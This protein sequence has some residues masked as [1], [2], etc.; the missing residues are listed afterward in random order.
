MSTS[1]NTSAAPSSR[2]KSIA[3]PDNSPLPG[4][5]ISARPMAGDAIY[6]RILGAIMEHRLTPGTK[7]VEE[8]L[9]SIFGVNRTR[10]RE[11]LARLSHEGLIT[12]IPNRGAFV[13]S[14]T[15][16]EARAIFAARRLLEPALLRHLCEHTQPTHI[17]QLR[18]HVAQEA[19]AREN[20]DR[21]A[22]IRLSGEFHIRIADMVE[23]PVMSKMMRELASL[24]CLIIVL[25]DS[26][27]VPACT[28]DEHGQIIDAI[29]AGRAE[30]AVAAMIE[31]LH[32]IEQV[33]DMSA[34][35][36]E[37]EDLEEML[38]MV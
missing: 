28:H 10:V 20:N 26:P 35:P 21:R 16:D 37:D 3:K 12:T 32:H 8:K 30:D 33:L 4:Q 5:A 13:A 6:E 31:H 15:P 9:A 1:A 7:L 18:E 24:T 38:G 14:P 25:Y 27:T 2:K 11:V 19:R 22:I 23:N 17:A 34:P 36:S 29:A